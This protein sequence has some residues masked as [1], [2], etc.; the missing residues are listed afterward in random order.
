MAPEFPPRLV[1]LTTTIENG[2]ISALVEYV[3]PSDAR[4]HLRV[5]WSEIETPLGFRALGSGFLYVQEAEGLF[6]DGPHRVA[7][8]SVSKD[9]YRWIQGTPNNVPWIMTAMLL[10]TGYTLEE[11][12]PNPAAAK[13]FRDSIA[14]YWVLAG[15]SMGRTQIE[16]G[17]GA[18]QQSLDEEIKRIN[19]RAPAGQI[20]TG[21]RIDFDTSAPA[22][23]SRAVRRIFLCYRRDD[24]GAIVGRLY[25]RLAREFGIENIF[26]DVDNV[27]FGV[28]FVEHLGREI[29]KCEVMFVVIGPRWFATAQNGPERIREP[30]DFVRIEILSAFRRGIPIVPVLVDG[31]QMPRADQLPDEIQALA[32]RQAAVIRHDPDFHIDVT[33]L[34]S[35]LG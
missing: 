35:R 17:I 9:R 1:V 28:D 3:E 19:A 30:N 24:S 20:P 4:Q 13:C 16:W 10:P 23:P 22:R 11:P 33:R 29:Q 2:K 6:F 5:R 7:V 14:V 12:Q 26:K 8:D 15:D 18:I 32:R 34:L 27:P 25:D 31:A 21:A